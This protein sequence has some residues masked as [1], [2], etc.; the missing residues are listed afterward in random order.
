MIY[1]P[2]TKKAMQIAYEAHKDQI[3]KSGVP[4]I[5]HPIH[6]AEQCITE[7]ACAAALLHDVVE[8]CKDY[9]FERLLNEGISDDVVAALKLLTH[10]KS[11]PYLEYVEQI[12]SNPIAR[13]VKINDLKHNLDDTRLDKDI[14]KE[15]LDRLEKKRVIYRQAL[16]MLEDMN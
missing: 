3:D 1:T 13:E 7:K 2:L 9:S 12:K 10:E 5:Y 15:V 6:V 14:E 11:E 4:Y 16:K 8:D